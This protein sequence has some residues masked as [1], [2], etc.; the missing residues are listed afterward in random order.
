MFDRRELFV[1]SW[2]YD[3]RSLLINTEI[4]LLIND[5]ALASQVA[6]RFEE[7]TEPAAAYALFLRQGPGGKPRIAWRTE[8]DHQVVELAKEPSRGWWQR[9]WVRVLA[10]LPLQ[11]EL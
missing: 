5:D 2:N 9:H 4:G 8:E 7:M 6:R 3:Q 10:L 1:G 11:P